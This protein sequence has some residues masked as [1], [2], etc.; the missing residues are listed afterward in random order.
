MSGFTN[1]ELIN[2]ISI[3]Q[4]FWICFSD[5]TFALLSQ[6]IIASCSMMLASLKLLLNSTVLLCFL[7]QDWASL[8]LCGLYAAYFLE[9][10]FSTLYF[11][12]ECLGPCNKH[13]LSAPV[14]FSLRE[15]A[16]LSSGTGYA[17]ICTLTTRIVI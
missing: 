9:Y 2:T 14:V 6:V 8:S 4:A 11:S 1:G 10:C 7:P 17:L 16:F 5:F 13:V 3:F 15:N 12:K